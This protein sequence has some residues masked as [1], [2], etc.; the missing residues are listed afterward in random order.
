[1]NQRLQYLNHRIKSPEGKVLGSNLT[2]RYFYTGFLQFQGFSPWQ[3][4]R[5]KAELRPH[6]PQRFLATRDHQSHSI[7][8]ILK[9]VIPL[10]I[11]RHLR[12]TLPRSDEVHLQ[13]RTSCDQHLPLLFKGQASLPLLVL[14]CLQHAVLS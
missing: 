7:Q 4:N 2:R 9:G 6:R 8:R 13:G 11:L 10:I 12:Q 5:C 1:M 3:I 14:L